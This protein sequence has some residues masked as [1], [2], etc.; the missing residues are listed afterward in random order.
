MSNL[1]T[2]VMSCHMTKNSITV[3]LVTDSRQLASQIATYFVDESVEQ[4]V[5][6][7]RGWPWDE[8]SNRLWNNSI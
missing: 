7:G 6:Y 3:Y 8:K 1:M 5:I 4:P 2:S